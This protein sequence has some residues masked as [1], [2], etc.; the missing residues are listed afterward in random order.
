MDITESA[1]LIVWRYH[2]EQ[3][4]YYYYFTYCSSAL[5]GG[6]LQEVVLG[7]HLHR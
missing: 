4:Q 1:L 5:Q 7:T 3:L 6:I 2:T